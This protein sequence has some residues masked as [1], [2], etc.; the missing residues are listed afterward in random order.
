MYS[1][2]SRFFAVLALSEVGLTLYEGISQRT[3]I[4]VVVKRAVKSVVYL[5]V[6]D[7]GNCI[8]TAKLHRTG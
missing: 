3:N 1:E 2:V 7:Q 6:A 4:V 5:W 8:A